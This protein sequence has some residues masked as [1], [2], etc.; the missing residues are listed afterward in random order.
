MSRMEMVLFAVL[1]AALFLLVVLLLSRGLRSTRR[2]LRKWRENRKQPDRVAA[3]MA[4]RDRLKAEHAIIAR[5]LEMRMEELRERFARQ[6]AEVSRARNRVGILAEK[7]EETRQTLGRR[8]AEIAAMKEVI[9]NLETDLEERTGALQEARRAL[10]EREQEMEKLRSRMKSVMGDLARRETEVETLKA[11]LADA[12]AELRAR[13]EA[14]APTPDTTGQAAEKAATGLGAQ[15]A[16]LDRLAR[17]LEESRKAL[18]ATGAEKAAAGPNMAEDLKKGLTEA[19]KSAARVREEL[20]KLD[21]LWEEKLARLKTAGHG[22]AGEKAPQAAG[23]AT[24]PEKAA[25]PAPKTSPP[26]RKQAQK[27]P[28]RKTTTR[29]KKAPKKNPAGKAQENATPSAPRATTARTEDQTKATVVSL[30][31]RI[32]NL[33]EKSS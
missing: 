32:R 8:E 29:K 26:A 7:L 25:G 11:R 5:R 12:E 16:H 22:P 27:K 31:E 33:K 13:G 30:A 24:T 14:F 20:E 10:R 28:G 21:A 17:E 19:E 23:K 18:A 1:A 15:I 6:E 3:L 9:S 2:G 4:E